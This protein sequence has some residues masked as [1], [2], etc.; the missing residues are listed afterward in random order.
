MLDRIRA[1][2]LPKWIRAA[3]IGRNGAGV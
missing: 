2:R 1:M 3:R